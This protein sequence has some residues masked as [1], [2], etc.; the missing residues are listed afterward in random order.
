MSSAKRRINSTGR[1]RIGREYVKIDMLKCLPG[2][3]LKAKA[4]LQLHKFGFPETA[5]VAIEAYHRSTGM[6]FD[7]GTINSLKVPDP[8]VLNEIDQSGSVLFRLKVVDNDTEPGRL[9]GSA[10]RITPGSEDDSERR[11]SLFPVLYRDLQD[12]IWKVEI[13]QGGTPKLIINRKLPGFSHKLQKSPIVQG[14][15]LPAALRFVLQQ[16]VKDY[17]T[18]EDDDELSWREEWLTYCQDELQIPGDPPL[19]SEDDCKYWIDQVVMQFCKNA[20]FIDRIRKNLE[21]I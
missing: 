11:R 13:E 14:L 5:S 4:S 2:E 18:G 7:C 6:R 19:N 12:D 8:L 3:P 1:T 20:R 9:L 15:I 10:E 16:L 21:E 17:D